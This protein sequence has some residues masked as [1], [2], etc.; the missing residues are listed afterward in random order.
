MFAR[1]CP[2]TTSASDISRTE[3]YPS[4]QIRSPRSP[5]TWSECRSRCKPKPVETG[6]APSPHLPQNPHQK[7]RR[8]EA[9]PSFRRNKNKV[10]QQQ[11]SAGQT[12]SPPTLSVQS[13]PT[14]STAARCPPSTQY[15]A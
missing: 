9:R 8:A 4:R 7:K 11:P 14:A 12:Q 3:S 2:P 6:L 1:N 10:D 13:P 5:S 15:P